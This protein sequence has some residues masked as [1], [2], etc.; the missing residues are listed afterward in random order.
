MGSVSWSR[1]CPETKQEEKEM[2]YILLLP[3]VALFMS[4]TLQ[5]NPDGSRSYSVD[6]NAAAQLI[7]IMAEK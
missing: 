2:K 7:L 1:E 3:I 5:V 6:P 4:C